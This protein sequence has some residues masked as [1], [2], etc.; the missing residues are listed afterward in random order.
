MDV[1]IIR[2]IHCQAIIICFSSEAKS[3][4]PE[5]LKRTPRWTLLI[6]WLKI[7]ARDFSP[8]EI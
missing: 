1:I 2:G 7:W 5:I 4:Q 6:R 3:Q 8:T